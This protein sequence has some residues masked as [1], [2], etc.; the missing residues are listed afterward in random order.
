[1]ERR[2]AVPTR[3]LGEWTRTEHCGLP[4]E[5]D[6]DRGGDLAE[7]RTAHALAEHARRGPLVV[8]AGTAAEWRRT[9][10]TT[11]RI[12]RPPTRGI[13]RPTIRRCSTVRATG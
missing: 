11:R 5:V 8:R 1:M 2:R 4:F 3:T 10:G 12:G 9:V 13:D 7:A 6:S